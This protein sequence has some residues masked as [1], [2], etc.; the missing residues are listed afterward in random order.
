MVLPVSALALEATPSPIRTGA[1]SRAAEAAMRR[2]MTFM[3]SSPLLLG[4]S[5]LRPVCSGD[6]IRMPCVEADVCHPAG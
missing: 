5:I 4:F 2:V 1:A 3:M 6:E